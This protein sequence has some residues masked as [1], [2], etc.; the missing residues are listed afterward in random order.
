MNWLIFEKHSL[1]LKNTTLLIFLKN[2]LILLEFDFKTLSPY[3]K[4]E[5]MDKFESR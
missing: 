1:M 2:I 3:F 5:I 4:F